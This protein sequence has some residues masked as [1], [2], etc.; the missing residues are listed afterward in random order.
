MTISQSSCQR[1]DMSNMSFVGLHNTTEG[2]IGFADSKA[3]ITFKDGHHE[4]D[5]QRGKIRKIFKNSHFI[6]V[7]YGNNE[8]F[9]AQF[10][11]N[12]EDYIEKYLDENMTYK[13]FFECLFIKLLYS[14]PEYSDG[15]YN[16]IIGSKDNKGQ[17]LRKLT[18][19][20]NKET[21]EYTDK[22]YE[23]ITICGGDETYREIYTQ[24][25]KYWDARIQEYQNIIQ[26][27]I[28][29]IV[30]ILDLDYKYNS[31]GVPINVEIFQ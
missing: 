15:I 25:P 2:I 21:Q 4:E 18:I 27:Q 31:V 10:K 16:F 11:I 13:D 9:S 20:T 17:Y 7:T 6:F 12:L 3:T 23:Y 5:V 19:N 26:K 22:N 28:S 30:E 1:K 8:L 24:I 14:K 29:K